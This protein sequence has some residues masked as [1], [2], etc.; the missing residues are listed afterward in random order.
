MLK[1]A[2]RD[3]MIILY[4]GYCVLCS[5]FGRWLRKHLGPEVS[6]KALQ[7]VEGLALLKEKGFSPEKVDEIIVLL[8]ER[9]ITGS[10]A[11]LFILTKA[12]GFWHW[13]GLFLKPVPHRLISWVYRIIARN[14]YHWFGKHNHCTRV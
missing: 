10:D 2:T 13:V 7:S 14:R 1:H 12:R 4:D 8:P 9:V 5:A 11:I 3:E 6:M